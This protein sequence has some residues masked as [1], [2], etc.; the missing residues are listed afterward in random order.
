[1]TEKYLLEDFSKEKGNENWNNYILKKECVIFGKTFDKETLE[2]SIH[3]K[4]SLENSIIKINEYIN[5]LGND[6]KDF[7][8]N[9]LCEQI[10]EYSSV[11][12]EELIKTKWYESLEI[13]RVLLTIT[14]KGKIGADITCEDNYDEDH[15]LDI[16]LLEKEVEYMNYDG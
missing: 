5:W 8:I 3:K 12:V 14:E 16:S 6:C 9:G 7:I 13:Y 4:Q 1:M 10:N 15:I 11:S 2:L